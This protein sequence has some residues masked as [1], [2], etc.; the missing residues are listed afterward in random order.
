MIQNSG[1]TACL[2]PSAQFE[3][4]IFITGEIDLMNEL[5]MCQE[6]GDKEVGNQE[7]SPHLNFLAIQESPSPV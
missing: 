3:S 2:L 1:M 4:T 6:T 7:K 5:F